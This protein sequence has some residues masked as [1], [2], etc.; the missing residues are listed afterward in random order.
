MQPVIAAASITGQFSAAEFPTLNTTKLF[1]S[2]VQNKGFY[3]VF[4][5]NFIISNLAAVIMC[6]SQT[7]D[8]R[9]T[10]SSL[11]SIPCQPCSNVKLNRKIN[12]HCTASSI[13]YQSLGPEMTRYLPKHHLFSSH[14]TTQKKVS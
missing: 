1:F 6:E 12:P 13:I 9:V 3:I 7:N 10:L 8:D 4:T 2:V 11:V 5:Y 14:V